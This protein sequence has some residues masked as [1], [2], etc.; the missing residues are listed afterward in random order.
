MAM[1]KWNDALKKPNFPLKAMCEIL[2]FVGRPTN[3]RRCVRAATEIFVGVC[4]DFFQFITI[5]FMSEN[6]R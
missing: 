6:E 3:K 4:M 1:V 2:V 5:F